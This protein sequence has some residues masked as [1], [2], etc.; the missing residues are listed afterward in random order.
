VSNKRSGAAALIALLGL[1]AL[2]GGCG[3]QETPPAGG[4]GSSAAG[5]TSGAAG[6]SPRASQPSTPGGS[7]AAARPDGSGGAAGGRRA[8]Q[9]PVEAAVVEARSVEYRVVAV[10]SVEAFEIVQVTARVQGVVEAVRFSEGNSTS[11]G[12]VLVEIEPERYRLAVESAKA[13]LEK[14]A[15]ARAEAQAG[16]DRREGAS[17]RQP[18][19]IPAE[20]IETWR[21]RLRTADA[22]VA[23]ARAALQQAELNLHDAYVRA[24]VGG[25]IETRSVQTGEYVQPGKSLATLLRQDPLLL[26]FAVPE[27]EAAQLQVGM[28]AR[29]KV[30]EADREYTARITHV[31]ASADLTTRMVQVTAHVEK[32]ASAPPR[33]GAFAEVTVPVGGPTAAA[34]VPETAVRPSERGFLAYVIQGGR[35]RERVLA[36]GMRTADGRVEGKSG[37]AAGESLVVRGAEALREGAPVRVTSVPPPVT[38]PAGEAQGSR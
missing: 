12:T 15:A 17:A 24:P 3:K 27:G 30:R 23:Q 28:Q 29:F 7:A 13:T 36:L 10:G 18:G 1:A 35:A 26:R 8:I 9:Y 5:G 22:E 33:P 25:I 19:I 2:A 6:G 11:S 16:L 32:S 38:G 14:A 31:A 4:A 34:V 21:T 37:I 20:E